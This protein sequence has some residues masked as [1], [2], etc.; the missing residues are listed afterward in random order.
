MD[1]I[2]FLLFESFGQRLALLSSTYLPRCVDVNGGSSF[3]A[4]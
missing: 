2:A 1:F 3:I 4:G